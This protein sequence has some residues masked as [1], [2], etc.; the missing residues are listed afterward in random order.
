MSCYLENHYLG[1]QHIYER[2]LCMPMYITVSTFLNPSYAHTHAPPDHIYLTYPY[3]YTSIF[4]KSSCW[5]TF[6]MCKHVLIYI[7]ISLCTYR[8]T[9][10]ISLS[11]ALT[12]S[13]LY[14]HVRTYSH[15]HKCIPCKIRM[16]YNN[17]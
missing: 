11:F 17:A 5:H 14:M 10:D 15:I 4:I 6:I 12:Y 7:T 2:T 16:I 8:F 3:T 13:H 9:H 1:S